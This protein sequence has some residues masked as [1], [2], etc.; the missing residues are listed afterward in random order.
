M[1]P[2]QT[3]TGFQAEAH[4]GRIRKSCP[5]LLQP[6]CERHENLA[7]ETRKK[8]AYFSQTGC[9]IVFLAVIYLNQSPHATLD[10][11]GKPPETIEPKIPFT[12]LIAAAGA[13][14]RIRIAASQQT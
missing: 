12:G 5:C 3:T 6:S 14:H 1:L 9:L 13:R 2:P 11:T 4:Q 7:Q 10:L 8:Q